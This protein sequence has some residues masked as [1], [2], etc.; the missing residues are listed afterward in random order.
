MK[1]DTFL[2]SRFQH[3][4]QPFVAQVRELGC[5]VFH[6]GVLDRPRQHF[7]LGGACLLTKERLED[8]V[9]DVLD[10]HEPQK[11]PQEAIGLDG[12]VKNFVEKQF[13]TLAAGRD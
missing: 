10:G 7:R 13:L 3:S 9:Q 1:A 6:F 5:R 4:N 12:M 2:P 11:P 8:E